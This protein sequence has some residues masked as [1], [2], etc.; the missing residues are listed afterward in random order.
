MPTLTNF[1]EEIF[2]SGKTWVTYLMMA[3]AQRCF[4]CGVTRLPAL[5]RLRDCF[6][7]PHTSYICCIVLSWSRGHS[8]FFFLVF[9]FSL[10]QRIGVAGVCML[11]LSLIHGVVLCRAQHKGMALYYCLPGGSY[12]N[13]AACV[14]VLWPPRFCGHRA[15]VATELLCPQSLHLSRTKNQ[16][17]H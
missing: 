5:L 1:D 4:M 2:L 8:H 7:L 16:R 3:Y 14:V 17:G 15:F 10:F 9:V 12:Y 6:S 11:C 13:E